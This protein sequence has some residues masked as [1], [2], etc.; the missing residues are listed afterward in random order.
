[1]LHEI[2]KSSDKSLISIENGGHNDLPTRN[3]YT[4]ALNEFYTK[5]FSFTKE[6]K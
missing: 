3:E 2:A 1:M 6:Q 4:N 5:I